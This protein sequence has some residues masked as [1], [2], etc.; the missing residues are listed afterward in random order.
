[1]QQGLG[2]PT[3]TAAS[4]RGRP[5]LPP[6]TNVHH[7][8]TTSGTCVRPRTSIEGTRSIQS[9]PIQS[10]ISY[11][12]PPD[13]DC[14]NS[15]GKQGGF[16]ST[17]QTCAPWHNPTWQQGEYKPHDPLPTP[18]HTKQLVA[19]TLLPHTI[20]PWCRQAMAAQGRYSGT[21]HAN[22]GRVNTPSR[23]LSTRQSQTIS[24]SMGTQLV[25]HVLQ[26]QQAQRYLGAAA[27]TA[28]PC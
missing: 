28:T 19:L 27:E 6:A 14:W 13:G 8:C 15:R 9:N 16:L 5:Q 26:K 4:N 11:V 10:I 12:Q 7:K 21:A 20:H 1:M 24:D 25:M 22:D 17:K 3:H 23:V 2:V 18:S